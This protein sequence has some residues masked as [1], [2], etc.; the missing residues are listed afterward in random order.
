MRGNQMF[1]RV[2]QISVEFT[3]DETNISLKAAAAEGVYPT[4]VKV[5][6]TLALLNLF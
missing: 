5:R 4:D 1:Y 6:L 3:L 2:F